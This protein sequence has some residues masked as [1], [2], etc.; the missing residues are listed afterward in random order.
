MNTKLVI[1]LFYQNAIGRYGI[2]IGKSNYSRSYIIDN[3]FIDKKVVY[4]FHHTL[5]TCMHI[6]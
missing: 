3:S 6:C 5:F 4:Q 2:N 1:L